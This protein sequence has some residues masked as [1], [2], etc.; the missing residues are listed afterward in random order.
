MGGCLR[1]GIFGGGLTGLTLRYLLSRKGVDTEVLEKEAALGGLMRTLKEDGFAF[2]CGGSHVIFSKNKESLD[3]ILNVLGENKVR[4]KRNT[5]VLYNGSYVKYPFE[6]GLSDLPK[7]E[8][9][10]CLYSFIE[11]LLAKEKAK[12][13]KPQNLKEWFTYTFGSGIAEKYLVPYNLKIWKHP[14]EDL[15]LDWVERVPNPPVADIVRSSLGIETEG[16]THQALFYYPL[17][18]GIQ[19]VIDSLAKQA[20][21]AV[22]GFEVKKV[23]KEGDCWVVS[24][25]K[26]EK[27][28]GK[29][30]STMPIQA[31]VKSMDAPKAVRIAVEDLKYTSLVSVMLG[32]NVAKI[33]DLSWLYIPEETSLSHRVS[34]PSNYSPFVSPHGKSSVLAEITCKEGDAT[35]KMKDEEIINQAIDDLHRLGIIDKKTICFAKA[36]RSTYAYVLND[37][38]YEANLKIVK[39][40]LNEAGIDLLGRFSEFKYLNMDA[41][42]ENVMNY[43]KEKFKST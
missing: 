39:T 36:K 31:I 19:S 4:Q 20:G 24:N 17:L 29:I 1:T 10:E 25:G 23:R 28:Y 37:T 27:V 11:K 5:K 33:N 30:I 13:K 41:C 7:Q 21:N 16:Y 2:D 42:V 38:Y 35:W 34:F 12:I 22:A 43:V 6:N 3:F 32:L 40:Y 14:L 15:T 18:G 8:N 9:F 26:Q